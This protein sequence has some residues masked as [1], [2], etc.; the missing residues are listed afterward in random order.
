MSISLTLT[1]ITG[2]SVS[3]DVSVY[4]SSGIYG[5]QLN[6]YLFDKNGV[7]IDQYEGWKVT[8]G[9]S[10]TSLNDITGFDG[11]SPNTT[12]TIKVECVIYYNSSLSLG[13][14]EEAEQSFTTTE[15][16]DNYEPDLSNV[17]IVQDYSQT[18]Y[19]SAAFYIT[20]LDPVFPDEYEL[21]V[22]VEDE[23]GDW[24]GT[25]SYYNFTTKATGTTTL[26]FRGLDYNRTYTAYLMVAYK[27]NGVED[28][29]ELRRNIYTNDHPDNYEPDLWMTEVKVISA[30]SSSVTL[31]VVG[32]DPYYS[33]DFGWEFNVRARLN[34]SGGSTVDSTTFNVAAGQEAT[35]YFTLEGLS[36]GQ[37]Y[38][39][40]ISMTYMS[41]GSRTTNDLSLNYFYLDD[42]LGSTEENEP[43][44][45]DL[46]IMQAQADDL[47]TLALC[48][49]GLDEDYYGEWTFEWKLGVAGGA[50]T[51]SQ[52][53]YA[54]GSE[55]RS[56]VAKFTGLSPGMLYNAKVTIKYTYGG[57][58]Y[59]WGTLTGTYSTNG[60]FIDMGSAKIMAQSSEDGKSIDAY[61]TGLGTGYDDGEATIKWYLNSTSNSAKGTT[62]VYDTQTSDVFTYT[63]LSPGTSYQ[64]YAEIIYYNNEVECSTVISTTLSTSEV[65]IITA[66]ITL[67]DRTGTTISVKITGLD[68][69]YSRSDR[70]IQWF[71][72]GTKKATVDLG[73]GITE[74]SPYTFTGLSPSTTYT[75]GAIITYTSNG[76]TQ[77]K[78]LTDVSL[79]TANW[80]TSQQSSIGTI[81]STGSATWT[82]KKATVCYASVKFS[83]SGTVTISSTGSY[84]TKGYL[85]T[86]TAFDNMEGEPTPYVVADDDSGDSN[87]FSMTYTVT[88]GT[89][90]YI[91]A[92]GYNATTSVGSITIKILRADKPAPFEW[93]YEKTQYGTF[94]LT[95]EEWNR[96]QTKVNEVRAY[97]NTKYGDTSITQWPSGTL[98]QG[99]NYF[100][101]PS[102]GAKFTAVHYNQVLMA[103]SGAYQARGVS[104]YYSKYEVSQYDD[105][106]AY[107][108]NVLVTLVNNLIDA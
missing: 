85:S 69:N 33:S 7:Q 42:Y 36:R 41:Y 39:I 32:L 66:S 46:A 25:P 37:R 97:L 91:W 62:T 99:I 94:N 81:S 106:T 44:G 21:L 77:T 64:L 83:T 80:A 48:V 75:I 27:V 30:T 105:V 1:K 71:I 59:T 13:V 38:Y 102:S 74:S 19:D 100:T 56:G 3:S 17:E 52:T 65:I 76:T 10:T 63:G 43:T 87:N 95:A 47:T 12:Y 104:G 50:Y 98:S 108:L 18:T 20:G 90:Y 53:T 79:S 82:L 73:A 60:D 58:T 11:L 24:V 107:C 103:I 22:A 78:E 6:S 9:S 23:Y 4:Y 14:V 35:P 29:Y 49:I 61:V 96:L 40:H 88:A 84:D 15:L 26:V 55:Y 93:T 34:S 8:L 16:D 101:S 28:S 5:Y 72:D 54:S 68:K 51:Y 45:D 67:A 31:Q 2:T 89:T 92:R 70:T 86:V 57:S